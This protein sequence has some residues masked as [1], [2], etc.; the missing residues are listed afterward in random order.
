MEYVTLNHEAITFYLSQDLK[1]DN[2]HLGD[3]LPFMDKLAKLNRP[4]LVRDRIATATI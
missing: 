4:Y 1:L 3:C 2:F